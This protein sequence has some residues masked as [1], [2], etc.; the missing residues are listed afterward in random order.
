MVTRSKY[1]SA[2]RLFESE[3]CQ[4]QGFIYNKNVIG[5]QFHP[6]AN[7]IWIKELIEHCRENIVQGLYIQNEENILCREPE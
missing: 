1:L 4:N 2:I 5:L 6:E 7:D 3:A